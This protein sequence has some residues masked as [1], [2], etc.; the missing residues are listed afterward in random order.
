VLAAILFCA[1]SAFANLEAHAQSAANY[2]ITAIRAKLF[3]SN[4]GTFSK[5]ILADPNISL[6]NTVIG[7]GDS[8]GPSSSTFVTVEVSG[9]G[10]GAYN[11]QRKL[12]FTATY[13]EN[14]GATRETV[15]KKV[16]A[17]PYVEGNGK[18]YAGFWLYRTGCSPVKL[19]AR[20]I[21]QSQASTVNRTIK[22]ACGE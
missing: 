15:I 13:R 11:N 21:G 14:G 1:A 4:T 18:F 16:V 22:F 10:A 19:T 12:E 2:K 6:W 17:V 3:Y 20:M 9:K 5:D 7:E 8:G